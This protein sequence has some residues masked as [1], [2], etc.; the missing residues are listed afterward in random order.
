MSKKKLYFIFIMCGL[1]CIVNI[2]FSIIYINDASNIFT[3][4]S[5]WISA[6]ATFVVGYISLQYTNEIEKIKDKENK[7]N[8]NNQLKIQ[9]NPVM[10]FN[11]IK[12]FAITECPITIIKE[13]LINRLVSEKF[14]S[15]LYTGDNSFSMDLVFT[16][17]KPE[18]IEVVKIEDVRLSY[19]EYCGDSWENRETVEYYNCSSKMGSNIKYGNLNEISVNLQLINSKNT[20]NLFKKKVSNSENYI[21]YSLI[22]NMVCSNSFGVS[23]RYKCGFKFKITNEKIVEECILLYDVN[24]FESSVWTDEVKI[25]E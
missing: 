18:N 4:V 11:S 21:N 10:F 6:I 22:V 1:A 24:V 16:A 19:N 12:N 13:E 23:K 7:K 25:I 20:Q 8:I 17:P 5:G 3:A 14:E 9:T 2:L 15:E